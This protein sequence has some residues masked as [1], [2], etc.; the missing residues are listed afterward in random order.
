MSKAY[1]SN[2]NRRVGP[3]R[4]HP[5]L[6]EDE[7]VFAL[8]PATVVD[9]A[10]TLGVSRSGAYYRLR[11]LETEGSI[12]REPSGNRFDLWCRA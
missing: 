8:L 12:R 10:A 3:G 5:N 11:A 6:M 2:P 9:I 4:G 7:Q 1:Y